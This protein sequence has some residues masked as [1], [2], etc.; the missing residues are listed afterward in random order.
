LPKGIIQRAQ[1][2]DIVSYCEKKGYALDRVS[3][4]YYRGIE[5]DS[6]VIDRYK[7]TYQWYS[8]GSYGNAINFAQTFLN[9][10]FRKAVLDLINEDYQKASEVAK[11]RKPFEYHIM[12]DR[13]MKAI[14]HYLCDIRGIDHELVSLL[15]KKNLIKQDTKKNVVFVWGKTGRRVG[16]D[17]QGTQEFDDGRFGNH[18]TF[19]GIRP[20]GEPNYGFNVSIGRPNKLIAFEAPIDLLSYWSLHKD[21]DNCRLFSMNG[22]K[23]HTIENMIRN[24]G[25]SRGFYPLDVFCG[26]DNDRAGHEFMDRLSTIPFATPD[27]EKITIHSLIPFDKNLTQ[28]LVK[29][30]QEAGRRYGVA[31][32]WIAAIHKAETNLSRTNELTNGLHYGKFFGELL[33]NNVHPEAI[34]LEKAI[35]DCARELSQYTLNGTTNI[36][37]ALINDGIS[38][39]DKRRFEAKV[40]STYTW[41]ANTDFHPDNQ[42]GK[43]WNDALLMHDNGQSKSHEYPFK[44][45]QPVTQHASGR[46]RA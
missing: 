22:L 29:L 11:K 2:T 13:D 20:N 30:Y 7:N 6:L 9:K 43:D 25:E 31:W 23:P 27:G 35:N 38:F 14:E 12:H 1:D 28:E 36:T 45:T 10:N 8:T 32:S 34:D 26:V 19:K 4:R 16:A 24:T 15:I 17:L 5:H 40:K 41:Y 37:D 39:E 46:M 44:R 42:T 33:P 3:D 21:L 18:T